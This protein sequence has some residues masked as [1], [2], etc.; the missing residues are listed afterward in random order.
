[1]I[2]A[3]PLFLVP[4]GSP[5]PGNGQTGGIGL[6]Q[7]QTPVNPSDNPFAKILRDQSGAS[8]FLKSLPLTV[9][10]ADQ[11]RLPDL[12]SLPGN[13]DLSPQVLAGQDM[14]A[15]FLREG[16]SDSVEL[17]LSVDAQ[18]HPYL[19]TF[20]ESDGLKI[21]ELEE[22]IP[23]FSIPYTSLG[24]YAGSEIGEVERTKEPM[25]RS[26]VNFSQEGQLSQ[27]VFLPHVFLAEGP[28]ADGVQTK[29]TINTP[30]LPFLTG[31]STLQAPPVESGLAEK[32]ATHIVTNSARQPFLQDAV[33]KNSQLVGFSDGESATEFAVEPGK[34]IGKLLDGVSKPVQDADRLLPRIPPS[35]ASI[36]QG[37]LR[38][39]VNQ[40]FQ[41]PLPFVDTPASLAGG[42]QSSQS[43]LPYVNG[44][45]ALLSEASGHGK[46]SSMAIPS[47]LR[48]DSILSAIGDRSKDVLEATGKSVGVD[49][50]GG[51]GINNGTG[52]FT[53]SQPGFQQSSSSHSPGSSVRMAEERAPDL[54][55]PALQRLQMD[56][57]L[58]ETNR[59]QIDVGVQNRHV[60]AGLLMDQA[61]LKNLAIQFV[62]QLE[63]QLVQSDM[64]LQ[65]FSAEV[66][67][68]HGEQESD[69]NPHLSGMSYG[70]RESTD[71]SLAPELHSNFVKRVEE[72]GLHLVA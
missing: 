46:E 54:P 44:V 57:Q 12:E 47:D 32:S 39:L 72:Q 34:N 30:A 37:P 17:P 61:T 21:T 55:T 23:T 26:P 50:N 38:P 70:K 10:S 24:V 22:F 67:D 7:P 18:P 6:D 8:S 71:L 58:S 5:N 1:M 25:G 31:Y 49:S 53:N 60:Y 35:P 43:R 11:S 19:V 51:Q 42:V 36:P 9:P 3:L 29:T 65:E 20:L 45:M 48:G 59:I 4:L 28:G 14:P 33:K 69:T 16:T 2:N 27:A 41:A 63:D 64:E 52:G 68:S 62:P 15:D 40:A 56:V 13:Q 66:R